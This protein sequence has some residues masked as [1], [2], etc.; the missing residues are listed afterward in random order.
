[1]KFGIWNFQK[2]IN[3]Q[4]FDMIDRQSVVESIF[5]LIT[6]LCSRQIFEFERQANSKNDCINITN[7]T[8]KCIGFVH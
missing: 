6:F 4:I 7:N 8:A 5:T 2:S 1:M 3:H